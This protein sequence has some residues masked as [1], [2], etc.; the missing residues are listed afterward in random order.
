MPS[1]KYDSVFPYESAHLPFLR[2]LGTPAALKRHVVFEAGHFLP[3]PQMVKEG[4]DWLDR[5]GGQ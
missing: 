4:L 1:G 3:R 2:L 5:I